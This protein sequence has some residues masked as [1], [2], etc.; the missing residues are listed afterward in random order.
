MKNKKG[1]TLTELLLT[2]S[3]LGII[4]GIATVSYRGYNLGVQKKDLKLSGDIF[5]STVKNCVSAVGR[6]EPKTGRF[7]CKAT[8]KTE[9]KAKLNFDC[10]PK[11]DC[12]TRINPTK[13][14][15]CLSIKKTVSGKKLQVIARLPYTNPED[16]QLWCGQVSAYVQ[17]NASKCQREGK[18][19]LTPFFNEGCNSWSGT[20][21]PQTS[22]TSTTTG[23]TPG[24][25]STTSTTTGGTPGDT[26]TT[27]TTTGG[28]PGDTSTTS[29]TTGGT[30]GETV[31]PPILPDDPAVVPG[32]E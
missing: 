23:G 1:Y 7:P 8:D 13:K 30:P 18:S 19:H 5:V 20:P 11:A 4:T 17:L 12:K 27:S 14:Y 25:T 15:Y 22:T 3:I 9:L 24:D 28:T 31:P 10:P 16:S 21:P 26:S 6:W 2:L 29:T 32:I